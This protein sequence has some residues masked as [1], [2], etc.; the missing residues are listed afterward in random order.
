M[1]RI[2]SVSTRTAEGG[3]VYKSARTRPIPQLDLL[4]TLFESKHSYA[5]EDTKLHIDADDPTKAITKSELRTLVKRL[6]STLRTAY[7]LG[8]DGPGRDA[9]LCI[10][11]G[12]WQLPTV[13]YAILAA[14]AIFSSSNPGSTPSELLVQLKQVSATLIFC[15]EDTLPTA[16][17]AGKLFNL[18]PDRVL[19]LSSTAPGL[20]L[21][22][23][24]TPSTPLAISSN[25]LS[26]TRVTD[27]ST[28][29]TTT[30]CVLFSSGTTGPP[31]ACILSHTNMTAQASLVL[32]AS[33][34]TASTTDYMA[35]T[36][37]HLPAAHI[38]GV[39]GYFVNS[40]YAGGSV[41]WM[42]RFDFPKFLEYNKK[43]AATGFFSVP[44]VYLAIAK[45]PAVTDHFDSL[46][47]AVTGAA[48]MG[49][50][51]QKEVR[52]KLGKGKAQV[53]QTWGL[54]ETTGSMTAMPRG[55]WNDE[56]GS[57][58]MLVS[59]GEARIVDEEG[60][61]V[62]P[63][64]EGEIWVRGP[65]VT[66]GYWNDEKA[67]REAFTDGWFKT[68]DVG[69]FRDGLFYIV[70]RKKELIKFKGN[71]V[72]P[73]ELEALLISHPLIFDAAVIGVAGEETE[74]PRAYI[75]A[76]PKAITAEQVA[77]WVAGRVGNHKKLR[78][79]VFFLPAIPKSPSGKILRK[80]LRALAKKQEKESKL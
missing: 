80:D 11:T 43:Y 5:K 23:L 42:K 67:N 14:G 62:Q 39:Q 2:L 54:S 44:P 10:A 12:H 28:L 78:G 1:D 58:S 15:T 65:Q 61:D 46:Q 21:T 29:D 8:K 7:G 33:R 27:P 74:V 18:P 36:I 76:D 77:A 73:A 69:L 63:G 6:A 53:C 50:E 48:P 9:V 79:G 57:V 64:Q 75:V 34:E 31:K 32:D 49:A 3:V 56:T 38:A 24:S 35:R 71:Q 16:T 70:D 22:P 41:Y 37:A 26:W 40:F 52:K 17:A 66:R 55:P 4:T 59:N 60:R 30:I 13:F 72:A 19:T 47:Y 20:T 51:L 25:L 45:S 68:G